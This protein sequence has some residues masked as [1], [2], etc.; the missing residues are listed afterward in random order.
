[1][2]QSI[3]SGLWLV[4]FSTPGE[5]LPSPDCW[6]CI[7][8]CTHSFYA[9]LQYYPLTCC[10]LLNK[11]GIGVSWC[12]CSLSNAKLQHSTFFLSPMTAQLLDV[13]QKAVGSVKVGTLSLRCSIFNCQAN[14][15]NQES[16]NNWLT[17]FKQWKITIWWMAQIKLEGF[18]CCVNKELNP[19]SNKGTIQS[20]H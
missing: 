13:V 2:L 5:R 16:K 8:E 1:M 12:F 11:H 10:C 6:D 19:I 17:D 4:T 18:A 3:L 20:H 15:W 9:W 14:E 7:G